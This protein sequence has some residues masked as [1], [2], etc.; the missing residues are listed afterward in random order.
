MARYELKHDPSIK[1]QL[2]KQL[3]LQQHIGKIE[4]IS[5]TAM[6]EY[7]NEKILSK[8]KEEWAPLRFELKDWRD[9]GKILEGGA[10]DEI[11]TYMDD[12]IMRTQTMKGSPYAKVF[13]DEIIEWEQW[14]L[15]TQEALEVWIKVQAMWLYLEP[16]FSSE[17]IMR[18]MPEEGTKFREVDR[19]WCDLIDKVDADSL[20]LK[21]SKIPNLLKTLQDMHST[22]EQVQKGLNDYLETKRAAFAR[23]YFLSNDELLEILSETKDPLRVQKH[24]K[25][26]FEGID[27]LEFD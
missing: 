20:A 23:F 13:L 6:K 14:L 10:V 17:D 8:M 11:Q 3:K 4:E 27:E 12:H 25:K 16:V 2:L 9:S 22:L 15:Y 5:D 21:V 1:L 24:L 19:V 26:C 7:S 18:Q